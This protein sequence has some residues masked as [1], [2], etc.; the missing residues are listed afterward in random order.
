MCWK[1]LHMIQRSYN[2]FWKATPTLRWKSGCSSELGAESPQSNWNTTHPTSTPHLLQAVITPLDTIRSW[3]MGQSSRRQLLATSFE[4]PAFS[5]AEL[6][7][8]FREP[9]LRREQLGPR[10]FTHTSL[11][12]NPCYLRELTANQ[13]M[14]WIKFRRGKEYKAILWKHTC[15]L[16]TLNKSPVHVCAPVRLCISIYH[17]LPIHSPLSNH[18]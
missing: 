4:T 6:S 18:A 15:I 16:Y 17:C 10:N 7:P 12:P 8:S 5:V 1:D 14:R 13:R 2:C 3:R 9:D 11:E